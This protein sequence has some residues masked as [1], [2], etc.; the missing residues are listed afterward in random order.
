VASV[1][2]T[3]RSAMDL[4]VITVIAGS[5]VAKLYPILSFIMTSINSSSEK[6]EGASRRIDKATGFV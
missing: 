1:L 2:G 4:P 6:K 3:N 5:S